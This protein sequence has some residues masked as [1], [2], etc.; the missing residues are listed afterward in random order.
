MKRTSALL[1]AAA[2]L[3]AAPVLGHAQTWSSTSPS[4]TAN[5]T[6]PTVR[7]FR[8][9]NSENLN[10]GSVTPGTA[11][12][13]ATTTTGATSADPNAAKVGI[14]FNA[15]TK[16]TVTPP[17]ALTHTNGTN[18]ITPTSFSCGVADDKAGL[19]EVAFTCTT[20]H[21]WLSA[22]VTSM[23]MK[24]VL[25]GGSLDGAATSNAL[26]GTYSGTITVTLGAS[27]S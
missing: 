13:V 6:I 5:A 18:T 3:V 7:Q 12:T 11:V 10:F 15:G 26:A 23:V 19:N 21:E 22:S 2:A 24:Y 16:V 27:S 20:G 9:D 1:L 4:I 17:S 25:I 14:R 8:T